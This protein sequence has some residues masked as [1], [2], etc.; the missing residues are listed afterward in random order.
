MK[1]IIFLIKYTAICHSIFHGRVALV[2]PAF[3][4]KKVSL[5]N[6]IF[7]EKNKIHALI[8]SKLALTMSRHCY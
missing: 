5:L 7:Q 3:F 8:F 2:Y 4:S 1:E 6:L